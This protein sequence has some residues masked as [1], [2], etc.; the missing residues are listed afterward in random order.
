MGRPEPKNAQNREIG[1]I[2]RALALLAALL[3]PAGARAEEQVDPGGL[4]IYYGPVTAY[5]QGTRTA[6]GMAVAPGMA[7]CP[8]WV[9][10]HTVITVEDVGVYDC[11]D[12]GG[13]IQQTALDIYRPSY[14]AAVRF[15]R[16]WHAWWFVTTPSV[17]EGE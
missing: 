1:A 2:V 5:S 16:Q 11:E 8:P 12:R 14:A 7:A 4:Q 17:G 15:G 3:L 13:D 6:S 10:F 9:P